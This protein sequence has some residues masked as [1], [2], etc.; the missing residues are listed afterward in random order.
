MRDF[1]PQA[2]GLR[3]YQIA[4]LAALTAARARGRRRNLV[5]MPTGTGKT[6]LGLAYALRR[7]RTLWLAHRDELVAQPEAAARALFGGGPGGVFADAGVGVVQGERDERLEERL[8][9]ASVATLARPARLDRDCGRFALIV[10]DEAHH[11]CAG[12]IYERIAERLGGP[13]TEVLGLTAT[14]ERGDGLPLSGALFGGC[15]YRLTVARAIEHGAMVPVQAR[16]IAIPEFDA[17]NV[18]VTGRDVNDESLARELERV[19]G[20]E[21]VAEAVATHAP[22]RRTLIFTCLVDQA[23]RTSDALN[24]RGVRSA[25]IH[26]GTPARE[27]RKILDDHRTGR[28]R[29]LCNAAVLTEGYDDPGVDCVVVARLTKSRPL[30]VQLVGRGLRPAPGKTSC[31]VLDLVGAH[32]AHGLQTAV[33]L[34]HRGEEVGSGIGAADELDAAAFELELAAG[35]AAART[36]EDEILRRFLAVAA[37][38]DPATALRE[39]AAA[40]VRVRADLSALDLGWNLGTICAR[41]VSTDRWCAEWLAPWRSRGDAGPSAIAAA[42]F[43]TLDAAC[44]RAEAVVMERGWDLPRA[45][46]PWRRAPATERQLA[47]MRRWRRTPPAG[48]TAGQARDLVTAA[49]VTAAY[50]RCCR[51]RPSRARDLVIEYARRGVEVRPAAGGA[52]VDLVGPATEDDRFWARAFGR[53][54]RDYASGDVGA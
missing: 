31:L 46:A 35:D 14:A 1:T 24:E 5:V 42:G 49:A 25:W 9:V 26:G 34:A 47:A 21:R 38:I 13:D 16:V 40:W 11:A 12:S 22:E 10:V 43:A 20:A 27:R 32:D 2:A 18:A 17:A 4:A 6:R 15:A 44:D 8:V 36:A 45:D 52:G 33:C 50:R 51:S 41:E 3:G 29:A 7:G 30:Y 54:M 53:E 48:C 19:H 28:I 23:K 37:R 39:R